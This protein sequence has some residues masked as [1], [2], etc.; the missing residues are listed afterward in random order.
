MAR[1][2]SQDYDAIKVA[3]LDKAAD[4]F[5][6]QGFANTSIT[7]ISEVSGLSKSGIY[8]YF[9]SKH[10]VLDTIIS[11]HVETV[12]DVVGS[13]M[14]ASPDPVKQFETLT[15]LLMKTYSRSKS[16]HTVLMNELGCLHER[17]RER[18]VALE[19][20]VVRFTESIIEKINPNLMTTMGVSRPVAMLF[21]G[22]INW[23]YTWY[24]ADRS[25]SPERLARM[26]SGIF[27]NGLLA[28]DFT[29]SGK[30]P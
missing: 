4:L 27:M 7:E 25:V 29:D 5:A 13:A 2:R 15:L 19:R 6:K 28:V 17:E 21:F 24:D 9:K 11:E 20:R 1:T 26:A 16:R 18:I 30:H 23:T 8:H 14:Q 10:E 12:F 22:M 3:I